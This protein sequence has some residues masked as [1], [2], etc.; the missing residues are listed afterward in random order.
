MRRMKKLFAY[1]LAVMILMTVPAFAEET[2]RIDSNMNEFA[3]KSGPKVGAVIHLEEDDTPLLILKIRTYHWNDG[4]GTEEP[5]SILIDRCVEVD[6]V[7]KRIGEPVSWEAT[8][9]SYDGHNNIY[10]TVYPDFVLE[11][12]NHYL[13]WPS[14]TSTWSYNE[15]SKNRG[16][17]ELT[18]RDMIQEPTQ[19]GSGE[20]SATETVAQI[21][22]AVSGSREWTCPDCGQTGNT[23][24]FC[25]NCAAKRPDE[26]WI[27]PNCGQEGNTGNFC[28]NCATKRPDENWTC[29]NCGQE[30]NTGNFCTN[31][32]TKRPDGQ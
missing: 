1:L 5:G 23:G 4:V 8:G 22:P 27:C 3:V 7:W 25:T 21:P 2:E 19:E 10:W 24:N 9:E 31:C 16:F 6:G 12:G 32:A 30:G 14:D 11:P 13:I 20:G 28:T 15:Q 18:V 17:V 29:P 26:G